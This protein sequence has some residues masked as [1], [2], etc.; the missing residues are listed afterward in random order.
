MTLW[1][2]LLPISAIPV[3]FLVG[4]YVH[5]ATQR[6]WA[7]ALSGLGLAE[8][9]RVRDLATSERAL[10][11]ATYSDAVTATD[12]REMRHLLD[13]AYDYVS[14]VTSGRIARL[15]HM[16]RLARM[17]S[18]ISPV[19]PM[20]PG[21]FRLTEL[22]SLTALSTLAHHILVGSAERFR[23]QVSMASLGFRIVVRVLRLSTSTG[24]LGRWEEA[25]DDWCTLDEVHVEAFRAIVLSL[26][27][28]ALK[29]RQ[30]S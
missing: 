30:A 5:S 12:P 22:R 21:H 11:R 26:E 27:A 16:A 28:E 19:P 14:G 2:W 10:I 7:H 23:L 25:L 1:W 6:Q 13:A 20:L 17:A 29:A 8:A 9:D 15:A 18:A 24:E 4:R 3:C